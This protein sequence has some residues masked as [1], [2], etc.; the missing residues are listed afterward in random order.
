LGRSTEQKR[1]FD[2]KITN[3][4]DKDIENKD[5]GNNPCF[6]IDIGVSEVFIQLKKL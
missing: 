3:K 4:R 2:G 5:F 6:M 1:N